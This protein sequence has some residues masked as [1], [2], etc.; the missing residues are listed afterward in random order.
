MAVTG[1]VISRL[2]FKMKWKI[3]SQ[4]RKVYKSEITATGSI[5]FSGMLHM[6]RRYATYDT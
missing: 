4:I 3:L 1:G 6:T 2:K 5:G